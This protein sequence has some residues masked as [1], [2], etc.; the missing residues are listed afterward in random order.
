[1]PPFLSINR[2]AFPQVNRPTHQM[3]NL[4]KFLLCT[5]YPILLLHSTRGEVLLVLAL[6]LA[7][8]N[9]GAVLRQL[10]TLWFVPSRWC[11]FR[12]SHACQ[13]VGARGTGKTSLLRLLLDTADLSPAATGDQRATLDGFLKGG[14][15]RT[16]TI[17]SACIEIRESR[18]DRILL[19]VIDTPG[20]E[21]VPGKELSVERQVT[22]IIKYIDEQYAATMNEVCTLEL[23]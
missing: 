23:S 6:Q 16:Q 4:P 22:D 19:T 5:C 8:P 3:R 18:Y 1:M 17:N 15:K 21:F 14:L 2:F 12:C 11:I 13:V 9:A 7:G 20:L 10:S